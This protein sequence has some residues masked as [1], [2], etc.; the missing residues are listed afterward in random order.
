MRP[1][2]TKND[3][4]K[5]PLDE[6][7]GS[8]GNVRILRALL[9]KADMPL[10][11]PAVARVAGITTQG[12][13]KALDRLVACGII[14]RIGSGRCK[15][16]GVR[17]DAALS[18][19]LANLFASEEE[20]YDQII[21]SLKTLLAGVSEVRSAWLCSP[22]GE[23]GGSL[24]LTVVVSAKDIGWIQEELR[25]QLSSIERERDLVVELNVFTRADSP[26]PAKDAVLVLSGESLQEK[27]GNSEESTSHS[28]REVRAL[29]ISRKVADIIRDDP[30]LIPRA[31]RHLNRL[32]QDD[33]GTAA[34][35]IAEWRQL[36]D[37]YS[38]E[39]IRKLLVSQTSRADRLRQSSPFFAILT[40]DERDRALNS[41]E[42]AE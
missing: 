27:R 32:M 10:S 34:K 29:A 9:H 20:R 40:A 39:R 7:F 12:A 8:P 18:N 14:E 25:S 1:I 26:Q 4:I 36:L 37:T 19:A 41:L 30:T 5:Y 33:Q 35:D 2:A 13:R 17:K 31:K 22:P 15:Q 42:G 16:Y 28:S 38:A 23:T 21:H 24:E 6:I 11:A 3:G